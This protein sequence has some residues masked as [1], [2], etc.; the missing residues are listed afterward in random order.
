MAF[1]NWFKKKKKDEPVTSGEEAAVEPVEPRTDEAEPEVE[2]EPEPEPEPAAPAEEKAQAESDEAPADQV[3]DSDAAAKPGFLRGAWEAT[4]KLA[5]TPVDP[6]FEKMAEGLNRTRKNL[7]GQLKSLFGRSIDEDFWEELEDIL[8][9]SDVGATATDRVVEELREKVKAEKLS[10]SEALLGATRSIIANIL[11]D[12]PEAR[13]LNLEPGRLNVIL[14]IGVNGAGKTTSTAKLAHLFKQQGLKVLLAAADTFRAAAIEQLEVWAGRIDIPLIRHQEGAD[15]AAVVYDALSAAKARQVDVLII[16]TAGRLHS[17]TN[18]MK[19]LEKINR[20][21]GRE[22]EGAPHEV[23][24]VLDATTGQNALQ[25]TR[26]FSRVADVSGL[27]LCKLDGT[28]KGGIMVAI[29]QEHQLP[30]KFIGVGEAVDD[31]RPFEP[32]HFL[33]ALFG[34]AEHTTVEK[35]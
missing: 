15:P 30:V 16:D 31:L 33:E 2:P 4:K 24:L 35:T 19:E 25:Q 17:K 14:M 26:E 27:V 20:V 34:E 12:E 5:L 21:A 7:V 6:W 3:P 29:A 23:L 8:L 22:V 11:G 1:A 32:S 9:T 13:Q 10:G 18:L 28:A